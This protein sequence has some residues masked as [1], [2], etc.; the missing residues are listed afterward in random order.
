MGSQENDFSVALCDRVTPVYPVRAEIVGDVQ[1][2]DTA[3]A[4]RLQGVIGRLRGN[5][6]KGPDMSDGARIAGV[7]F[8]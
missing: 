7:A 6:G 1:N 4:Q 5:D 8:T 2:L 3:E